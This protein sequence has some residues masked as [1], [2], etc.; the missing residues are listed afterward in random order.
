M[1][2]HL[3]SATSTSS[4]SS[5]SSIATPTSRSRT[6]AKREHIPFVGHVP[7]RVTAAE[8]SDAGQQSIEHLTG[9]LRACS[10]REKRLMHEQFFVPRR[11]KTPEQSRARQLAWERELLRTQ[12]EKFTAAL[13][14]EFVHNQTWQVP[15]LITLRNVAFPTPSQGF[16]KDT[17]TQFIPRQMLA[18]WQNERAKELK[19]SRED[20]LLREAL[21]QKSFEIVG[22]MNSAGVHLMAGTDT[23]APFVFPGSSLHE[24]LALLVQAGLTPMQALQ[25]ATRSPAEFL[26]KLDEQGTIE[27]GK[28]AD[29]VLLDANPL[30]DIRGTQKIRAVVI[31]GKLLERAALDEMLGTVEKFAATQ[32]A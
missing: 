19:A 24:E 22:K 32:S 29:L 31:R 20:L 8:A 1:S 28:F 25:S 3:C 17:R 10:S 7:D 21:L 12:S 9:V 14:E 4:K 27:Q 11:K 18:G 23:A 15:T 2:T 30:A 5:P 13:L 6:A 26:G 16:A